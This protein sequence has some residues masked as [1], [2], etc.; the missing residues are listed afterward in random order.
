MRLSFLIFLC[1]FTLRAQSVAPFILAS[2]PASGGATSWSDDFNRADET[3]LAGNWTKARDAAANLNLS[4]NKVIRASGSYDTWYF[5]NANSFTSAQYSWAIAGT[6]TG[7]GVCVHAKTGTLGLVALW[8]GGTIY[9]C[10]AVPTFSAVA[11][12]SDTQSPGDTL[13]ISITGDGGDVTVSRNGTTKLTWT[14][15][16]GLTGGSAGI[17]I[18]S[19]DPNA[20]LDDWSGGSGSPP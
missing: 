6:G 2:A 19:D 5:W 17:V 1:S 13:Q 9:L 14:D 11:T 16:S 12:A 4:S 7:Q 20:L 10:K 3:P 18:S 15:T 8:S